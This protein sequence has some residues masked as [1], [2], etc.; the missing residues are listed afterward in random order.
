VIG[1]LRRKRLIVVSVNEKPKE[2]KLNLGGKI[3]TRDIV[4]FSRQFAT[5]VDSGLPLVQCLGILGAQTEN[6]KFREVINSVRMDVEA[7]N[8][9]EQG[10]ADIWDNSPLFTELRDL[11]NLKGK[12][13]VCE[14]RWPCGGCRARAYEA[15]GDYLAPEPYCVYQ[16]AAMRG[17]GAGS[18]A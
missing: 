16:P 6:A 8:T 11:S 17:S 15:T 9:R 14:Y 4:I 1:F 10:F 12:C 5:M 3:K 18:K 2:I 7:G 13:G